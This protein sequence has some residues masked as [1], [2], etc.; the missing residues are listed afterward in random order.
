M[1]I[2]D[3]LHGS[4]WGLRAPIYDLVL[5][6][7]PWGFRLRDIEVPIR[8]WHGDADHLVPLAHGRHLAKLVRD[9]KL[10]VRRGESHLGGLAAAEEVLDAI[11]SLWPDDSAGRERVG[12]R[13]TAS[14]RGSGD[15]VT[16]G[17]R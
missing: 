3:L 6:C 2:D 10:S 9:S 11:L 7:R 8:F 12:D 4:R 17:S 13:Q 16:A 5:F 15:A 14:R 1:F